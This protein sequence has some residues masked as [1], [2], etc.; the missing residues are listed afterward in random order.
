MNRE[1]IEWDALEFE[2]HEKTSDWYWILGIL[3]VFGTL[4]AIV[5]GNILFALLVIMSGFLIGLY[6]SKHP[7]TLECYI[8][9]RGVHVNSTSYLYKDID[10]F[11]IDESRLNKTKLLLTLKNRF[12]IQVAIPLNEELD[13]DYLHEYLSNYAHEQEQAESIAEQI[14]EWLKL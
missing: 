4:I 5:F 11:W 6:A 13:L 10:S 3:V 1:V 9:R 7:D 8:D 2:P 12:A 14:I